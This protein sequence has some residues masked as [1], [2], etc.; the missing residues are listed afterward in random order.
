[1]SKNSSSQQLDLILNQALDHL[2]GALNSSDLYQVKVEFLGKQGQLTQIMKGLKDLSSEDRPIVGA[3]LNKVKVQITEFYEKRLQELKQQEQSSQISDEVMDL[4]LPGPKKSKGSLHPIELVVQETM[5]IF[6]KMGYVRMSGPLI[7]TDWY[8]FSALNI[9]ADHPSRDNNDTFYLDSTHLLRTHTSP[10]QIRTLE[11]LKPPMAI[12]APGPVFRRDHPDSSHSPCFHQVEGLFI[13]PRVS[14]SDLKGTLS[15]FLK[16]F[17]KKD[18]QVRFRSSFFP[19]TEPSAEYD[20]SC[21]L[22]ETGCSL[23]KQSTWIEMGG[24]GL[25]HPQV[26]RDSNLD[27]DEWQGFAFGIGI[28]RLALLKYGIPDIRILYENRIDFLEQFS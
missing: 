13:A 16:E 26:L 15:Y 5:S 25:V 7:E 11:K 23:C 9:P 20:C 14:M 10:V 12:V 2:K 3:E 4:S 18:L 17:Y 24:A 22:C 21:F 27:P 1:M 19:F 28:D 6:E 8:N